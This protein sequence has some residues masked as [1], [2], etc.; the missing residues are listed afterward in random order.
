MAGKAATAARASKRPRSV[1][2]KKACFGTWMTGR[3]YMESECTLRLHD[4]RLKERILG[5]RCSCGIVPDD[6]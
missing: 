1:V 3:A 2:G 4:A 5:A 6:G